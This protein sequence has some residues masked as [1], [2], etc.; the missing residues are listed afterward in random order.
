[1]WLFTHPPTEGDLGYL[2]LSVIFKAAI[3]IQIKSFVRVYE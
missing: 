1:M 3:N 2:Q